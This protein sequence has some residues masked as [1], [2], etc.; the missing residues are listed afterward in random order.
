[1][2]D[3]STLLL[4]GCVT[5][6]NWAEAHHLSN[7]P[8]CIQ[9]HT[10][11]TQTS[12]PHS[13]T[14]ISQ[15]ERVSVANAQ[16]LTTPPFG[17]NNPSAIST[18]EAIAPPSIAQQL[19]TFQ[20]TRSV[21][22][23]QLGDR[24]N[25]VRDL[26]MR[27]R[28][29][30]YYQGA[31]DGIYGSQTMQAVAALQDREGLLVD[32]IAGFETLAKLQVMQAVSPPKTVSPS[33]PIPSHQSHPPS[34]Q[35][36]SQR[37][38]EPVAAIATSDSASYYWSLTGWAVVYVGGFV[39]IAIHSNGG[40]R[41]GRLQR[42]SSTLKQI[43]STSTP[44]TDHPV[45]NSTKATTFRNTIVHQTRADQTNLQESK[46]RGSEHISYTLIASLATT[47]PKT[48]E[49]YFYILL[50]DAQSRFVLKGN[51][52]YIVDAAWPTPQTAR[53]YVV[54]L[55]RIDS[56]GDSVDKSFTISLTTP[57]SESINVVLTK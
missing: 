17:L 39:A 42:S 43:S 15:P 18:P 20:P 47:D 27:L 31:I 21:I 46:N 44:Q 25:A 48:G 34:V 30:G 54:T 37:Q 33:Q 56:R 57:K 52:L 1:M 45:A 19:S 16:R 2:A 51:E 9:T 23:L 12:T 50:D 40:R 55:R 29:L 11:D 28:Q 4:L 10:P 5:C 3:P 41:S 22:H 13:S 53:D 35:T 38:D 8:D 49:F 6:T 7:L 26:Q 32:G 14:C 24:G 36:P